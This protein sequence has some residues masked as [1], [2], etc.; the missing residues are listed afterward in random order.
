MHEKHEIAIKDACILFDLADL[1]LL[2]PFFQLD[3]TVYTTNLVLEEIEYESQQKEIQYFIDNGRLQ[4]DEDVD[5]GDVLKIFNEN[6]GLT[7]AD[8]SVLELA[9][10]KQAIIFSSDRQLRNISVKNKII[11]RGTLWIIKN[12]YL[13]GNLTRE[14]AITKLNTY[15]QIN[16]RAPVKEIKKLLDELSKL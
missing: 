8:C 15:Q 14:V 5:F 1:A 7:L 10:R 2:D 9:I 4:I 11:V 6:S 3:F 12:L 16:K 13:Q